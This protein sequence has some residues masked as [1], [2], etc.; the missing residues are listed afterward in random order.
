[1]DKKTNCHWWEPNPHPSHYMCEAQQLGYGNGSSH[2]HF[3]EYLCS[4]TSSDPEYVSQQH[5]WLLQQMQNIFLT[6]G[7]PQDIYISIKTASYFFHTCLGFVV[8]WNSLVVSKEK[9]C[10]SVALLIQKLA[11]CF[12][13]WF[14]FSCD[15]TNCLS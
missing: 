11:L 10:L 13:L 6:A 2:I 12:L 7:V 1:M 14:V 4:C 9:A 8:C 15:C 3:L 5:S